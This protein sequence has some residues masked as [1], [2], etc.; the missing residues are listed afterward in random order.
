M[1]IVL[2][3]FVMNSL[4]INAWQAKA[5]EQGMPYIKLFFGEKSRRRRAPGRCNEERTG[6]AEKNVV[7]DMLLVL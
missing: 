5:N 2:L 1:E 4:D 7:L 6:V 3:C